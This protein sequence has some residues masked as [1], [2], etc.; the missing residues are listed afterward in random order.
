MTSQHIAQKWRNNLAARKK[1]AY[2]GPQTDGEDFNL[3]RTKSTTDDAILTVLQSNA[4]PKSAYEL[5]VV[6]R[7][8]DRLVKSGQIHRLESDNTYFACHG[9]HQGR[10]PPIFAICQTCKRVEEWSID[11]IDASL[12]TIAETM[13]FAITGRTIEIQGTCRRCRGLASPDAADA[14]CGHHHG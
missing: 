5:L 9:H 11:S 2:L 3:A 1:T 7:A 6:D 8:L 4:T 12:G 13:G 14:C 10:T